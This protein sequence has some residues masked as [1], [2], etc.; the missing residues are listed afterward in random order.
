MHAIQEVLLLDHSIPKCCAESVEQ[1]H[2]LNSSRSMRVA[3]LDSCTVRV[4]SFATHPFPL[5]LC[6]GHGNES[7]I[8]HVCN[9]T[10]IIKH[11]DV[12]L[13][14][15]QLHR[16]MGR[17]DLLPCRDFP[18]YAKKPAYCYF[19]T[20][21]NCLRAMALI[22]SP[23]AGTRIST[24]S[25]SPEAG[26]SAS[27]QPSLSAC[28]M[29]ITFA[30]SSGWLISMALRACQLRPN[31]RL[32]TSHEQQPESGLRLEKPREKMA[33]EQVCQG[34]VDMN[35]ETGRLVKKSPMNGCMRDG[36]SQFVQGYVT[37]AIGCLRFG[38]MLN[39]VD[40]SWFVP[41][42]TPK[43]PASLHNRAHRG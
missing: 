8:M 22:S 6:F 19:S 31:S 4:Y 34:R 24:T 16:I 14:S 38:L 36:T 13:P 11:Q 27:L 7:S 40:C 33:S 39:D 1:T 35:C 28:A 43:F 10:N 15:W 2:M 25:T 5:D 9:S 23:E 3:T 26:T 29:V 17:W 12:S 32:K 21:V 18:D 20:Q 37:Y 41:L 42:V 30:A